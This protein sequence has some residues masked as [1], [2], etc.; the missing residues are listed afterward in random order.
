M[1]DFRLLYVIVRRDFCEDYLA[2]LQKETDHSVIELLC[3]GTATRKYLDLVGLEDS[4]KMMLGVICTPF[5]AKKIMQGLSLHLG[6]DLPGYGIAFTMP[7]DSIGGESS[8][9]ELT[10]NSITGEESVMEPVFRYSL[11]VAIIN[12]GYSDMVMDAAR[13]AGAKGG[14]VLNAKGTN[15][16]AS[17]FGMTIAE[18]KEMILIL[19]AANQKKQIMQNIMKKAGIQSPAHTVLFSMPVEE[20][21]GLKSVMDAAGVDW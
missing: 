1:V 10:G 7:L 21:A 18:E 6:L 17:F 4:E 9:K 2:Y 20:V 15:T 11:L 12:R 8:L 16:D 14:T 19:L 13:E 3:E 5:L